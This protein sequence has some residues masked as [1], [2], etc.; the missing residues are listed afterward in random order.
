[1]NDSVRRYRVTHSTHYEY[2]S[3]SSLCHNQ[4][5]LTPREL[6]NQRVS[7]CVIEIQPKPACRFHWQDTFG[8]HVEFFSI[9]EIHPNLAVTSRCLVERFDA[10][11]PDRA[12]LRWSE[13]LL[14]IANSQHPAWVAAREFLY[15]SRYCHANHE[16]AEYASQ[17]IEGDC[18]VLDCLRM[19]NT[20]IHHEFLYVPS[21]TQV[22]TRPIEVLKRKKG[23]C[24]DFAHV[25][26]CCM[27]S[28]GVPARYVSG[29]LLTSPPKGQ[30]RLIGAD[31]S[32]AWVSVFAGDLGWIDFD[33]TNNSIPGLEHITVAWGRDYSDVAPI[34]GVFVGGGFTTLHVAVDVTP[35]DLKMPALESPPD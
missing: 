17:V 2:S 11:I 13:L 33:P 29:Y 19:L 31:A 27:R 32:H 23:V 7:H 30:P 1:M 18:D 34:Q 4:L 35:D 3:E 14:A 25:F 28:L 21:S 24:Q 8:N 5:H 22:T 9:E 26:I 10:A 6:L 20:K 12:N 15:D 16:F